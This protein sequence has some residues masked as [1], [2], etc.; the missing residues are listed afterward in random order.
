MSDVVACA[1]CVFW[2]TVKGIK[3]GACHAEAPHPILVGIVPNPN[4]GQP[5][6]DARSFWPMTGETDW[7]GRHPEFASKPIDFSAIMLDQRLAAEPEGN[8]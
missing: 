5:Y 4:G 7:C 1:S 6:Y 3:L 8:G 2:V